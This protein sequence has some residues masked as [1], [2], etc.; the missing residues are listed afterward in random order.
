MERTC[1][2]LT[3][4]NAVPEKQGRQRQREYC[5]ECRPPRNRA[6]PH[7]VAL[8]TR[9]EAAEATLVRSHRAKLETAGVLDTPAGTLVM[10]LAE[11]I[12]AG[13]GR[14]TA[15]GLASL[16]RELRSALAAAMD[17]ALPEADVIDRIFGSA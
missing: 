9:P 16:S 7:V 3:C 17:D 8:P 2:T 1:K 6:N 13:R 12:S 4:R 5:E 14:H 10:E 15:A 11:T